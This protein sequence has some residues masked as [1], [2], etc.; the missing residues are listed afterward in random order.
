MLAKSPV[1]A[2]IYTWANVL[3]LRE[4]HVSPNASGRFTRLPSSKRALGK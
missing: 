3:Q 4:D 2:R 1:Q